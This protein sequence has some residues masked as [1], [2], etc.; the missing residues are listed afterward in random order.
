MNTGGGNVVGGNMTVTTTT[1]TLSKTAIAFQPRF[2]LAR[3]QPLGSDYRG[4][5]EGVRSLGQPLRWMLLP[6]LSKAPCTAST[7]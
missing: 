4:R 6:T 5:A 1:S 7:T 2:G 3:S